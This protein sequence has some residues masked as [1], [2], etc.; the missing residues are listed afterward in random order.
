MSQFNLPLLRG[1]RNREFVL[2]YGLVTPWSPDGRFIA[3]T[4]ITFA[5]VQ[6]ECE[7]M[8]G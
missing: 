4:N 2:S 6:N 8:C 7:A 5:Q 3:Y 1:E